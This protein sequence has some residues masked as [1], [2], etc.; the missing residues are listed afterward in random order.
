MKVSQEWL[1]N[2]EREQ[3]RLPVVP[4]PKLQTAWPIKHLCGW[5][6]RYD[7]YSEKGGDFVEAPWENERIFMCGRCLDEVA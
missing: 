5:C 2:H 4:E 1:A 7:F 6:E 3:A